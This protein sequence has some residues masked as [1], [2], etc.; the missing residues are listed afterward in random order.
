VDTLAQG[1]LGR[2]VMPPS[3]G[4]DSER[5]VVFVRN[6]STVSHHIQWWVFSLGRTVTILWLVAVT[7]NPGVKAPIAPTSGEP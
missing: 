7:G 2:G 4:G 1:G 3:I 6:V 5:R